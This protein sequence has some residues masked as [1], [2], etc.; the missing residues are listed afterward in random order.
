MINL[1]RSAFLLVL[2]AI[3]VV[4][5]GLAVG[6]AVA[7]APDDTPTPPPPPWREHLVLMLPL[8]ESPATE[9]TTLADASGWG[10]NGT[11][12]T[13]ADDADKST[14]GIGRPRNCSG[15]CRALQFDGKDDYVE[16]PHSNSLN[17]RDE[18][19]MMAWVYLEDPSKDQ[20]IVGKSPYKSGYVLGV[21]DDYL[22][23]EIWD[24]DGKWYGLRPGPI[25]AGTWTHLAVTWHSGE[26]M[27]GYING[28]KVDQTSASAKP[29]GA[30][31]ESLFIGVGPWDTKLYAVN[32]RIDEV[33]ILEW[34]LEEE[35]I[36]AIYESGWDTILGE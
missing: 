35:D 9:G 28:Q 5:V 4:L 16:V 25:P 13:G 21:K 23:P 18:L 22:F 33:A 14:A 1:S 24:S 12:H 27:I 31:T 30:N 29:I 36:K 15:C 32:G 10:N 11:L 19:T 8:D 7:N 26:E 20:K 3:A 6:I 17:P 2:A 34:A